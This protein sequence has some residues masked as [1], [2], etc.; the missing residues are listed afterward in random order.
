MGTFYKTASNVHR[1][2]IDLFRGDQV[3]KEGHATYVR[4]GIEGA[5]FVEMD[6]L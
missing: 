3:E 4:E 1:G 6:L 2:G 5:N